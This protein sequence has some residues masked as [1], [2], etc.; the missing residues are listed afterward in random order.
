MNGNNDTKY[1]GLNLLCEAIKGVGKTDATFES[2]SK[3]ESTL[4]STNK[5]FSEKYSHDDQFKK[6][7]S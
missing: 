1:N 7:S 2:I 6:L 4:A 3:S 5:D